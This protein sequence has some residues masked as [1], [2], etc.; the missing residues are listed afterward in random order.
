MSHRAIVR[1]VVPLLLAT[2]LSAPVVAQNPVGPE[3]DA[4]AELAADIKS[5]RILLSI[6]CAICHGIDGS[7][8]RG[9]NL[10]GGPL[11]HGD[12]DE[13]I[14]RN[15]QNGV[16]GT[17]MAGVGWAEANTWQVVRYIQSRRRGVKAT[18]I[19]GDASEGRLLF[20]K[21]KCITCHWT[22]SSGGRLGPDLTRSR[23]SLEYTRKAILEPNADVDAKYQQ[24]LLVDHSG[25]V[26]QGLRLNENTY[27]IQLIDA[28]ER[29][30]TVS[31]ADIE[32]LHWPAASTMASY[33]DQLTDAEVDDLIKYV[34]SLRELP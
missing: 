26:S 14:F 17:G 25:R 18:D 2:C 11:R 28:Q 9:P 20:E 34:F 5:G 8:G 24:V 6:A 4:A 7:G 22:V 21:N 30:R 12:S 19:P 32:E 31:M 10:V 3:H 1:N 27:F 16:S 13:A 33:R 23:G 29:L 15:I